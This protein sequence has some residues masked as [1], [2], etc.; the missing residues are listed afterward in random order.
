MKIGNYYKI[1]LSYKD[2]QIKTCTTIRKMI[3]AFWYT[4]EVVK[5]IIFMHFIMHIFFVFL[6]F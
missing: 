6:F 2:Y 3:K 5:L 4:K 1:M